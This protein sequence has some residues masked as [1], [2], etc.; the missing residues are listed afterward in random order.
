[1]R[2][3]NPFHDKRNNKKME[4]KDREK[5][6]ASC[7]SIWVQNFV[8]LSVYQLLLLSSVS[9]SLSLSVAPVSLLCCILFF[10]CNCSHPRDQGFGT[11]TGCCSSS[12]SHLRCCCSRASTMSS[13]ESGLMQASKTQKSGYI[14]GCLCRTHWRCR[15]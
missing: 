11:S 8:S 2:K 6:C 13:E 10:T 9:L 3:I 12:L 7:I 4:K 1:M 15:R 14:P 5:S